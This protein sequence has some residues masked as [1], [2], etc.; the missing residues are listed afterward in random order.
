MAQQYRHIIPANPQH[1]VCNHNL[2][3]IHALDLDEAATRALM[4]ILNSTLA[5]FIKPY[6]GRYAGT[7]GNLKTEVVDTI[8]I[9]VPDPRNVTAP[10]LRQLQSA[11]SSMQDRKVTHLVEEAFLECHT[12]G[13][14]REAAKL[15]LGL[16][17][18]LQ[19]QDRRDLD[20][21]VFEMLGVS[22]A[23]RRQ[24]LIDHLYREVSLH[25]RSIRIMEVQKM[26]QRRHGGSTKIST[27]NLAS[28]AWNELE[29]EWQKPLGDWI[30]ERFG[31]GKV[32]DLPDGD[33]RLPDPTHFFEANT[34]YFGKKPAVSLLCESRP[35]AELVAAI[36]RAGLR[37]RIDLPRTEKECLS[38]AQQL[39]SRIEIGMQ[40]IEELAGQYAGTD[41]IREQVA[42]IL[43]QWFVVGKPG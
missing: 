34:V 43:K 42:A 17:A 33:V 30:G 31:K 39:E 12:A 25:Y 28:S 16:P 7:E 21:A 9:E 35:E 27:T 4:P 13:E 2:F 26:E 10:I 8:L 32:L 41:K 15:P 36:A 19:Q 11:F 40:K 20:D 6:Y 24:E 37:G 38:L 29:P 1:L 18:E 3:D 5:A 22:D 14:V 23:A